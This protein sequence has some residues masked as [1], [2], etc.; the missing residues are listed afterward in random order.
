MNDYFEALKQ[1]RYHRVAV[2]PFERPT[3]RLQGSDIVLHLPVIEFFASRCG[4]CTEFGVR[5]GH[6]TVALI[7]GCPG[8]V[9]SYDVVRTPVVNLL[10]S[11]K[12]PCRE[13]RFVLANTAD[14]SL[15]VEETDFL[16]FDTLHT[17]DHLSKELA[18]HGRKARKYVGFHDTFTCGERDLSG[19]DPAA[20]GILPAI[21]EFV[22]RHHGQ[23]RV[24]YETRVNNGMMVWERV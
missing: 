6:S 3:T 12:L 20:P 15:D 19:P 9:V 4:H 7:A 11:L 23:Y 22:A 8:V 10:Q 21:N 16:F 17:Y 1:D 14:P 13:W 24:V 18:L 5:D 2:G